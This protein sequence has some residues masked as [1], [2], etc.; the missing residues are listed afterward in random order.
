[1]KLF[2]ICFYFQVPLA[3]DVIGI[4]LPHRQHDHGHAGHHHGPRDARN[5]SDNLSLRCRG[6]V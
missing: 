2:H 4:I 6:G 3:P 5:R 1:V